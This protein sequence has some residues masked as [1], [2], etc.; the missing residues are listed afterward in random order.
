MYLFTK[1]FPRENDPAVETTIS[2]SIIYHSP[3]Q[4]SLSVTLSFRDFPSPAPCPQTQA[5]IG[6]R[7]PCCSLDPIWKLAPAYYQ[8]GMKNSLLVINRGEAQ[9]Q[10]G[11]HHH[12]LHLG[13]SLWSLPLVHQW[14]E[15]AC[16][17]GINKPQHPGLDPN[18]GDSTHLLAGVPFF[19]RH[20]LKLPNSFPRRAPSRFLFVFPL[21]PRLRDYT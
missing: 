12:Q 14:R 18:V 1:W 11:Y 15:I 9:L 6:T 10:P 17:M 16:P 5:L 21:L 20:P 19:H 13:F 2:Q 8:Q 3:N 7:R 4:S